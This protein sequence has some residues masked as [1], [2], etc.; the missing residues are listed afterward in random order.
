[1]AVEEQR[2]RYKLPLRYVD[3]MVS[4]DDR[5]IPLV[6]EMESG[7]WLWPARPSAGV[8]VLQSQFVSYP[9]GFVDGPDAAAGCTEFLPSAWGGGR[10]AGDP[11]YRQVEARRDLVGVL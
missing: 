7:R 9:D 4:K 1:V 5:I 2:R 8:T 11:M 10:H 6:P 3:H